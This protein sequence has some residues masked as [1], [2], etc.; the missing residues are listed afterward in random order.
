MNPH[1]NK[2]HF[3]LHVTLL[4]WEAKAQNNVMMISVDYG[5]VEPHREFGVF[6]LM[7]LLYD[8]LM[9]LR[10]PN[11][12]VVHLHPHLINA[13]RVRLRRIWTC[14]SRRDHNDCTAVGDA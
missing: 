6:W 14:A 2:L 4:Y 13:D 3:H 8:F 5:E 9:V 1:L 11:T 10:L 12:R 7:L